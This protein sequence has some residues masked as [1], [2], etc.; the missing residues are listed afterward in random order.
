MLIQKELGLG[1]LAKRKGA[2]AYILTINSFVG[3]DL[4]ILLINGNMRTPKIYS[5]YALIDYLNSTADKKPINNSSLDSSPWLSGFLEDASFQLRASLHS[6]Y[7]R[8]ECK[9][10]LS[11]RRID[12][13]G[14]DNLE[15]IKAIAELFK[16]E[17]KEARPKK[18]EYRVR[19]VS[20]A[21]NINA[22]SYLVKYPLFGAKYLDCMDWMKVLDMFVQNEHRTQVGR[23]KIV[24]IKS[25]INDSRT[26]FTWDHL[27]GFYSL[28]T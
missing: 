5:L 9:I 20:L 15:F 26:I 16:T 6:K 11:Q 23:D 8:F 1:S 3:L 2:N 13:K 25:G 18:P 24:E 12:H 7:P 22:K 21:G 10:E 19:T 4:I 14:Y 17:V 27:Q 28:K